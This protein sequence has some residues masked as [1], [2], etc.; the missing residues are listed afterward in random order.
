MLKLKKYSI[1][2]KLMSVVLG[3]HNL[4]R[5]AILIAA[6]FALYRMVRGLIKKST[7]GATDS[8]SGLIFT[9]A[10]DL[11]LLLG[12]ILYFILS[13]MVKTFF[14]N[15]NAALQ[16]S[17]LRYWGLEHI[18]MM[19]LAVVFGHLGSILAKKQVLDQK[20]YRMGALFFSIALLFLLAG[21]P[22]FRP[23]LPSF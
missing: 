12:L 2:E 19:F 8:K 6:A 7:W 20:K 13:P 4:L 5:W 17:S 9:I 16:E 10:L 22:W 11:Q 15:I 21:I 3:T 18:L 14:A 23:L 1:E